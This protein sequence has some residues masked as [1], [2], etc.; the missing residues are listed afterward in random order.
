MSSIA[1]PAECEIFETTDKNLDVV[2]YTDGDGESFVSVTPF[3][4]INR[5]PFIEA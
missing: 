2:R 5:I 3:R 1:K 4:E